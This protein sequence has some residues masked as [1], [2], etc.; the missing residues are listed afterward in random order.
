M[1]NLTKVV[2]YSRNSIYYRILELTVTFFDVFN[3]IFFF[4]RPFDRPVY[5]IFAGIVF[6]SSASCNACAFALFIRK[7]MLDV[8]I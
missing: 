1:Q 3:G 2:A 4:I 7:P 8:V 5:C 6:G